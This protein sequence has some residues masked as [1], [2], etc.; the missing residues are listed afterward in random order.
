MNIFRQDIGIGEFDLLCQ[1]VVGLEH[2][3]Q[4]QRRYAPHSV[5]SREIQK[6]AFVDF[7][8]GVVVVI[9]EQFLWKIF[10]GQ[11]RHRLSP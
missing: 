3:E 1:R 4:G 5:A 11:A 9:V 8:V 2:I 6:L 7:T 10:G